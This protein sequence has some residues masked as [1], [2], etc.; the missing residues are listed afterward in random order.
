[1]RA[2]TVVI[3]LISPAVSGIA[4]AMALRGTWWPL[5]LLG[6]AWAIALWR[7][8]WLKK[9]IQR[10]DVEIEREALNEPTT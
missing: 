1:M 9:D 8:R 10:L 4:T 2:R 3:G 5:A 6:V 7:M